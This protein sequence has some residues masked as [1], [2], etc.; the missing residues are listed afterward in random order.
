MFHLSNKDILLSVDYHD[1]NC[2][3]RWLDL[4]SGEE[5]MHGSRTAPGPLCSLVG[6]ALEEASG[7]GGRVVWVQESTSG[8]ARMKELL[9]EQVVFELCNVLQMP[10]PPKGRRRKTDKIDTGRIQRERLN[11]SLPL[12]DQPGASWRQLRR[13]VG[14]HANLTRRRTALRNWINRYLAHESWAERSGL[15]SSKGQARLKAMLLPADDRFVMDLKLEEL[16]QLGERLK[17]VERELMKFYRGSE[18]AQRI[19][20]IYGIAP[21]GAV[22]IVARI[23]EVRRFADAE[24]LVGY[25]GLAP[26]VHQSDQTLRTGKLPRSGIDKLLR[27]YL[28]EA[29]MWA[30]H[31]P[32]YRKSYQRV[33]A[34]HGKKVGRIHVA[35]GVLRSIY[36]MLRD[37]VAFESSV[38]AE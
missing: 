12:A 34:R 15:W 28:M 25:A 14:L 29:S 32:R 10:L 27:F 17:R 2:K 36:K 8:W 31:L 24:Q 1:E 16:E 20:A 4:A 22:A 21:I 11:G 13:V 33:A 18:A 6:E 3:L 37:G 7:R 5:R 19:D 30:R 38:A 35:R 9:G 23:G 26:G